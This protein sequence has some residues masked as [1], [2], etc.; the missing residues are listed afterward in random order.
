MSGPVDIDGLTDEAVEVARGASW[1][2]KLFIHCEPVRD[3]AESRFCELRV[4]DG[5]ELPHLLAVIHFGEDGKPKA[6]EIQP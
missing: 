6:P 2:R 5:E 4:Y 1:G 3:P